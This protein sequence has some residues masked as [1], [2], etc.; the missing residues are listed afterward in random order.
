[1]IASFPLQKTL[2]ILSVFACNASQKKIW[3]FLLRNKFRDNILASAADP[4]HFGV[5]PDPVIFVIDL[6]DAYKKLI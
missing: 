2:K 5:D 1:M 3:A 4:L 6:Q